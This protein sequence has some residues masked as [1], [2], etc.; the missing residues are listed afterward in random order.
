M[1]VAGNDD[2]ITARDRGNGVRRHDLT[3]FVEDDDVEEVGAGSIW[4]TISGLIAQ[5]GLTAVR[6]CGA[7]RK[8]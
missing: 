5:H 7:S 1:A 2:L 8:S 4:L 3:G 6:T